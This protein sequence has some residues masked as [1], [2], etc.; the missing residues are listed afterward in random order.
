M[1]LLTAL[2]R[3]VDKRAIDLLSRSITTRTMTP[4]PWSPN[5][6]PFARR[7]DH[8]DVYNSEAK[9]R[10]SIPDPYQWLEQNTKETD[11]WTS[12][13]GEFT[14]SYLDKNSD[15]Q[16]LED[17]FRSSMD[18]AKVAHSLL[19]DLP[20]PFYLPLCPQFSAPVLR[21]DNRWY[22]TYNSG[23]QAQLGSYLAH[24]HNY[25]AQ[26]NILGINHP[27]QCFIAQ[28]ATPYRISPI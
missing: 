28:R 3:S 5:S 11:K 23:L 13:Q 20:N 6:Y 18:Y 19:F 1:R 22:W 14:R 21:D 16:K 27:H 25:H 8:V 26:L 9:G 17:A 24:K 4:T 15:R 12:A 10:V 2:P 7:S